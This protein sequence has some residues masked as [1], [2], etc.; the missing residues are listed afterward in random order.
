MGILVIEERS[1]N[2]DVARVT[3]A[4]NKRVPLGRGMVGF[5]M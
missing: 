1:E 2:S 5:D 4:A 3:G